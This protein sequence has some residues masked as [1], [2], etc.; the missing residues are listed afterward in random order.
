M[1]APTV[2]RRDTDQPEPPLPLFEVRAEVAKATNVDAFDRWVELTL[3]RTEATGD[4]ARFHA[5]L[6]G[7]LRTALAA[8]HQEQ[9]LA[10]PYDQRGE[11]L[12]RL[13][14]EWATA[15]PAH[16]TFV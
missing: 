15:H 1:T 12:D 8:V 6:R 4:F 13:A 3:Q 14:A 10:A 7:W 16:T 2:D 9:V 11:V 5:E